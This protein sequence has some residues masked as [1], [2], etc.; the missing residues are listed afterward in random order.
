MAWTFSMIKCWSSLS[1]PVLHCVGGNAQSRSRTQAIR[2]G[3]SP[4]NCSWHTLSD[5]NAWLDLPRNIICVCAPWSIY[6]STEILTFSL[7]FNIFQHI[8]TYFSQVALQQNGMAIAYAGKELQDCDENIT[9]SG[10]TN[11]RN[12]T[13]CTNCTN[14]YVCVN[15]IQLIPVSFLLVALLRHSLCLQCIAASLFSWL[16]CY[17]SAF[18]FT[19]LSFSQSCDWISW[20]FFTSSC[21]PHEAA[22]GSV[23]VWP[24]FNRCLTVV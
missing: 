20:C 3:L 22:M 18:L 13:N 16:R 6:C 19:R 2:R 9:N 10:C 15:C 7:H 4:R 23:C 12:C 24:L 14:W 11:C 5:C 1:G 8:S 17:A 21:L